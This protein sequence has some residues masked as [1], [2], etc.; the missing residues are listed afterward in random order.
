[1]PQYSKK[2]EVVLNRQ[3]IEAKALGYLDRYDASASRL[4][5]VLSDF[6]TR[7]AKETGVDPSPLLQIVNETLERYQN[8]GLLDDRRYGVTMARNLAAR[9]AS[10][11]AIKTKLFGRGLT[12]G[13]VDD[14]IRDLGAQGGSEL[15]AAQALVRK[16]KLGNYRKE[17]ERRDNYRRDLGV[18]ARA[19]FDFDTAKRALADEGANE[20]S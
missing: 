16:R 12:A 4:R 8:N 3:S 17:S 5:R 7:R 20:A 19:G 11:Q 13:V 14:V 2:R 18:L 9:G 10:R 1:M 15:A 6:V